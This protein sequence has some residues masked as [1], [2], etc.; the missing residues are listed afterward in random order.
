MGRRIKVHNLYREVSSAVATSKAVSLRKDWEPAGSV[1]DISQEISWF[2]FPLVKGNENKNVHLGCKKNHNITFLE[3]EIIRGYKL[4]PGQWFQPQGTVRVQLWTTWI[5]LET[6]S[7]RCLRPVTSNSLCPP[8]TQY[9]HTGSLSYLCLL[10][11]SNSRQSQ[12]LLNF[13]N[14]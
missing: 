11:S 13:L 14:H 6:L 4:D 7:S 12:S 9:S 1:I 2:F 5:Y 10:Y 8:G 3:H